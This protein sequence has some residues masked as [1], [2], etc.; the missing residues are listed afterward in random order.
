MAAPNLFPHQLIGDKQ[1]CSAGILSHLWAD[2]ALEGH[3]VRKTGSLSLRCHLLLSFLLVAV[4][5]QSRDCVATSVSSPALLNSARSGV[6]PGAK[7]QPDGAQLL[8]GS[9]ASLL[10]PLLARFHLHVYT[11]QIHDVQIVTESSC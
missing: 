11:C 8:P 9:R 1:S 4:S 5:A 10:S 7:T 2:W 6:L 3:S